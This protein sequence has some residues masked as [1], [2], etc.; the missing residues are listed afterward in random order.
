MSNPHRKIEFGRQAKQQVLNGASQLAQAVGS[1]MGPSG[2]C[3]LF[4]LLSDP[5]VKITKDGVTV[6]RNIFLQ[7]EYEDAGCKM[8]RE[9][10]NRTNRE[11]GDGTTATVIIA[12]AIMEQAMNEIQD[13]MN[14]VR[15][16]Q[17]MHKAYE[18]AVAYFAKHSKKVTTK[19]QMEQIATIAA[20]GQKNIGETVAELMHSLGQNAVITVEEGRREGIEVERVEGVQLDSG[21]VFADFINE[22]RKSACILENPYILLFDGKIKTVRD[23]MPVMQKVADEGRELMVICEDL[24]GDALQL[25][26]SN[27]HKSDVPFRGCFIPIAEFGQN[28]S[29]ALGD[30]AYLT[31]G[32]VASEREGATVDALEL[33]NLGQA[34]RIEAFKKYTNIVG[35][36]GDQK[37]LKGRIADMKERMKDDNA[38]DMEADKLNK[39]IA[40]LTNGIAV[41]RV[42]SPT[43]TESQEMI[44]RV[45]DSIGSARSAMEEGIVEGGGYALARASLDIAKDITDEYDDAYQRG[46]LIVMSC[47]MYPAMQIAENCGYE[48]DEINQ[49]LIDGSKLGFNAETGIYENLMESGVVDA[50]KVVRCAL[51]NAV[52]TAGMFATMECCVVDSY[53]EGKR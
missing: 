53:G 17:G 26:I 21:F 43:G 50:S 27:H 11:S 5:H 10:A 33:S 6:T 31:G 34:D 13:G 40:R 51:K 15:L 14:S 12:H 37:L 9:A 42:G 22:P 8:L 36:K 49:K 20:S 38:T 23:I 35:A 44:D 16:R 32:V 48:A 2:R 46:M 4:N 7:D 19:K 28:R 41:I 25:F 24:V 1:T 30:I 45:E 52:S 3:V 47:M 29:E 18:L 39:R